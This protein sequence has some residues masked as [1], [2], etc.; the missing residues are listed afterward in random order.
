MSWLSLLAVAALS[1]GDFPRACTPDLDPQFTICSSPQAVDWNTAKA[2][3]FKLNQST[4]STARWQLPTVEQLAAKQLPC[5]ATNKDSEL[6]WMTA[7]FLRHG[8]EILVGAY[9]CGKGT[10]EFVPVT[11]KLQ[12]LLVR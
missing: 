5:T 6:W 11:Q 8:D 9:H 7:A 10:T 4:E 2:N 3:I 12:L 1:T